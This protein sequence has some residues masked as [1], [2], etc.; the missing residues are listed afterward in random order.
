MDCKQFQA[1][2]EQRD[3]SDLS[4][5]DRAAR[6][7][8][9]CFNCRELAAKDEMLDKTIA[10]GLAKER[11]PD[12]LEKLVVLNL[13]AGSSS[14]R[15]FSPWIIKGASA[16]AGV[17]ALL[18]VL[19]LVPSDNTARKKF[20]SAL[21]LDHIELGRKHPVDKVVN[22]PDWLGDHAQFG[23]TLPASSS[24]YGLELI[25]ARICVIG[26][27]TTVHLVYRDSGRFVS[28]Y[29]I[30]AK[31]VPAALQEGK[32]Y[33]SSADG[34]QVKLWRENHQVYALIS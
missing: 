23:A 15:R 16:A 21:A 24:F 4:E 2:L 32:T 18:L 6:H 34:L 33:T 7:K 11:L 30:D 22:L 3:L 26:N 28:L 8:I 1:W 29:I 9:S 10:R 5:A 31:Q 12:H 19:F 27:C 13:G 17:I 25:G 14:P 20:G